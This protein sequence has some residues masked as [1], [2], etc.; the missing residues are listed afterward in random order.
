MEWGFGGFGFEVFG[1]LVF[2]VVSDLEFLV[3]CRSD[4]D[5]L[6]EEVEGR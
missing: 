3:C 2:S 1:G 5:M 4:E 6:E